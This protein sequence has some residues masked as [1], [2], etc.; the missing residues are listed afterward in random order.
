MTDGPIEAKTILPCGCKIWRAIVKG[1]PVF[2]ME[3]C[4]DGLDCQ[5]V[6]YTLEQGE[7]QGKPFE[8]R[9]K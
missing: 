8:V 5:Y 3:A 1:E 4:P 7:R 6:K 9:D 2:M